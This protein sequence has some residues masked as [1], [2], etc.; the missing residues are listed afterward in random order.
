MTKGVG[1]ISVLALANLSNILTLSVCP[2]RFSAVVKVLLIPLSLTLFQYV[3][4]S[5]PSISERYLLRAAGLVYV[6]RIN[7]DIRERVSA[8]LKCCR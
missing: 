4:V 1:I 5:R 7:Y 3:E 6:S 2:V 8:S